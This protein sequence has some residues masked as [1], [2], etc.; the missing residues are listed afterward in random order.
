MAVEPPDTADLG[1]LGRYA[2]F[3]RT[4]KVIPH[5]NDR[6]TINGTVPAFAKTL[7]CPSGPEDRAVIAAGREGLL[8]RE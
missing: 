4:R 6:V 3:G 2:R 8:R 5:A 1:V 7:D